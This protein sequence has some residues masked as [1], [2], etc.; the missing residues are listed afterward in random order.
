MRQR[1]L[2]SICLLSFMMLAASA[3]LAEDI[4][5]AIGLSLPPYVISDEHRGME[6]DVAK[7]ALTEAGY[8]LVPKYVP[9]ARVAK[10]IASGATDAA[11]TQV[12]GTH[13]DLHY[14]DAI[15][16][17]QN[18]AISLASSSLSIDDVSALSSYS[19]V[20][21]QGAKSILG[22]EFAAQATAA[23]KY[24]EMA[25]QNKQ[26]LMMFKGRAQVFVGDINIFKYFR[27]A[28]KDKGADVNAEIVIHEVFSPT[29]FSIAFTDAGV[30][31]KVNTALT[32]MR[33]SGRYDEIMTSYVKD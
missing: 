4:T 20:A 15:I 12:P 33:A 27:Q 23:P 11:L 5:I 31:A 10:S 2:I 29:D 26:V 18:V 28:L 8:T 9:F 13:K 6:L 22:E 7:E 30:C 14:S 3:S 1:S 24:A 16:T 25:D 19:L 17:Y 21:F 32:A